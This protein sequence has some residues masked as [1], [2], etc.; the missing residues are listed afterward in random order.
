ML[1][2]LIADDHTLI[3]EGRKKILQA[4]EGIFAVLEA[5]NVRE[6]IE[7]AGKHDPLDVVI[8]DLSLPDKN[9]LEP[10]LGTLRARAELREPV[11]PE[12]P[13]PVVVSATR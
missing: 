6:V 4:D 13:D 12:L 1:K 5:H 9:G 10:A 3:R 2:V 7:L 8:L 11:P